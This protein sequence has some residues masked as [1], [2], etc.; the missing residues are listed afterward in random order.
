MVAIGQDKPCH[1]TNIM[2]EGQA[3][4]EAIVAKEQLNAADFELIGNLEAECKKYDGVA[5]KINW[6]LLQAREGVALSDFFYE[7]DGQTVAYLELDG[8]G[9][10]YELTGFVTPAYRQRGIFSKLLD[11]ARIETRKRGGQKLLLVNYR[12]SYAG[13][14][15]ARAKGYEYSFSEYRMEANAANMPPLPT[16]ELELVKVTRDDIPELAR[17]L[18]G[19]FGTGGWNNTDE[20]EKRWGE[21]DSEYYF[22]RLPSGE[23]IGQISALQ[24]DGGV[25][26]RAVGIIEEKRG[27][28]YGRQL[29]AMLLRKLL[30]EGHIRFSL[31]VETANENALSLYTSC[32]FATSNVYDYYKIPL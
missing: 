8:F 6:G 13:T 7:V 10:N 24:E 5:L 9:E 28:G 3:M 25:Y 19:S 30:D 29:L 1:Y 14:E 21:A 16:G 17:L 23:N 22:A 27:R 2:T 11:A 32:G 26:I 18:Q 12:A 4:A 20:L 31:D 15:F